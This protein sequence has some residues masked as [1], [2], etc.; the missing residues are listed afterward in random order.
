M[1]RKALEKKLTAL[2]YTLKRTHHPDA[3][4]MVVSNVMT[5]HWDFKNLDGVRRFLVD[6]RAL[7][8]YA[9]QHA[10]LRA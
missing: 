6:E 5:Y 4:W 2:G 7:Y 3:P 9:R 10:S 8:R 1:N